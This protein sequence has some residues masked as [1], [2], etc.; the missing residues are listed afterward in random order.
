MQNPVLGDTHSVF[1]P[2]LI[3]S[4]GSAVS[5]CSSVK[6]DPDN[7]TALTDVAERQETDQNTVTGNERGKT[8]FIAV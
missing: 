2:V 3:N 5:N 8:N 6:D 1:M 4:G 7:L